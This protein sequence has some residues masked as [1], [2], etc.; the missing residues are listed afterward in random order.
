[1]KDYKKHTNNPLNI[2]SRVKNII[3]FQNVK[4]DPDGS[5]TGVPENPYEKPIQDVD[6]L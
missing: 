2:S 1:M 3:E 4:T 5:Y 6:D